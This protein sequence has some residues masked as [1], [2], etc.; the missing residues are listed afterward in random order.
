MR[1]L[2]ENWG[3]LRCVKTKKIRRIASICARK[4]VV[5]PPVRVHFDKF[6]EVAVVLGAI[7]DLL[8][9]V[10]SR[11]TAQFGRVGRWTGT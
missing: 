9:G 3:A 6:R 7:V 10:N 4:S 1:F 8:E 11:E 2:A 5:L